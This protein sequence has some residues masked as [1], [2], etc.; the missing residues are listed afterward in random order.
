MDPLPTVLAKSAQGGRA[1][2]SLA[3]H[4]SATLDAAIELRC[5]IGRIG[6]AE[7]IVDGQFWIAVLW[8]ALSHDAGKV[9]TGFQDMITRRA[10]RWGQRHEVVSLGFL[11]PL[12]AD[13]QLRQWVALGVVTH[14]RPLTGAIFGARRPSIERAYGGR[15]LAEFQQMI[16]DVDGDQ[17]AVLTL[18]LHTIAVAAGV[19]TA[20]TDVPRS[21]V[22]VHAHRVLDDLL[23]DWADD[24][25]HKE[26][27]LTAILLQGAVTLA[28]HLSSAHGI[29]H[30]GQPI[31]A[32]LQQTL[33]T[34]LQLHGHQRRAAQV[35]DHLLLRAPTGTGKTEA[36]LLWAAR[37]VEE[38]IAATGGM[39][40]VF[41]TLPYLASINAMSGRLGE[42]LGDSEAVGVS[43]SR[44]ASY[45]L[46][47]AIS[48]EDDA[49]EQVRIDAARKAVA[50]SAAT[51]LFKE[52][53]RVGTPYQLLRGALAGPI[54]AG[55][56]LDCANSVFVLDELHAYEPD[57]LGYILATARLWEHLG[58]RIAVLSATL[59]NALADL[60]RD[61]LAHQVETVIADPG[62]TPA[63]HR[64]AVRTRGLT[65]PESVTEVAGRMAGGEAVLV[66]A[67]NVAHAQ[68]LYA[69]LAPIARDLHGDDAATLLHSRYQRRHRLS[70]EQRI[71]AR[72]GTSATRAGR[73]HPG[74]VVATQVVEVSLDVDFDVLFTSAAPLEALL[75]RFGRVNRIAFREP[76]DVIVHQPTYGPR[77]G[78]PGQEFADGIYPR[79][80]VETGWNILQQHDGQT[81][82]ETQAGGWLDEVYT[83]AWG[84][85]WRRSVEQ[86]RAR[87][88]RDFLSFD[89]P[90][91]DRTDLAGAFDTMFDGTEAILAA[92]QADYETALN[93]ANQRAVGKLI[94][95]DYLIPMPA[96][97]TA[98]VKY[99]RILGVGIIDGDYDNELGLLSVRGP[100]NRNWY[101]AGELL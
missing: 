60:I 98:M 54:H 16:G 20:T 43:H 41:Y 30:T 44:S 63:R 34:S 86:A 91:D 36:G 76:A 87:F 19:P 46:A 29:L 57:R 6:V 4:L 42:Q 66:V 33:T 80:P 26:R 71:N 85:Q 83:T 25:P 61:T 17:V 72:Y 49:D 45:H 77:R 96:W 69:Q 11:P 89:G 93:S 15:D 52:T 74:L 7:Q 59:P 67:N 64:L 3:A 28:D 12:I 92:H 94:A 22:L 78:S 53:V 13:E 37:Q 70:I 73:R 95:D 8:A 35:S 75:Q 38:L 14:H 2:E 27:N 58:G 81:I 47:I 99:D 9:A 40:R 24:S 90:F 100:E 50:R 68:H 56:V 55:I 51:R 82:D 18:W 39:P 65:E 62:L 1:A 23:N 84:Q 31:N 48:P 79:F 101:R 10:P 97:A 5:R 21:D 32:Q 88:E